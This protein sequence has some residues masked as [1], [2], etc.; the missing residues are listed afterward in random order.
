M[1]G[2]VATD[3]ALA[4]VCMV[5]EGPAT[6]PSRLW[7][8]QWVGQIQQCLACG[9]TNTLDLGRL[10]G[11]A[12]RQLHHGQWTQLWQS[13]QIPFSRVHPGLTLRAARQLV[14]EL[15]R[16]LSAE[17]GQPP[18]VQQRLRSFGR[19]VHSSLGQWSRPQRAWARIELNR[20]LAEIGGEPNASV[21][22]PAPRHSAPSE[23]GRRRWSHFQPQ[24]S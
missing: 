16:E 19:L 12:K 18:S 21:L 17:G 22:E 8:E 11:S 1:N 10:L 24:R 6:P 3:R 15:R 7:L 5:D 20:L 9:K 23:R 13:G 14:A 2:C 4:Q